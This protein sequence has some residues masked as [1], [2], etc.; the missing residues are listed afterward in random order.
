VVGRPVDRPVGR[1][2]APTDHAAALLRPVGRLCRDRGTVLCEATGANV[3]QLADA[4]GYDDRIGRKFLDGVLGFG[5]G[6]LP[7]DICALMARGP[8]SW[9][10]TRR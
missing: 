5:G 6:C 7:K 3:K 1:A 2:P 10:R 8:A 9:A 4:I